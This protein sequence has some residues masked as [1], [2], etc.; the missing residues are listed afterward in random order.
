M[1]VRAN[2]SE[3]TVVPSVGQFRR[4]IQGLRAI[5]VLAVLFHHLEIPYFEGGYVGVDVFFVISGYLITRSIASDLEKG[6]FRFL[7]FY[8][9]RIRRL[10]PAL[11]TT[12]AV[13]LVLGFLLLSPDH[14]KASAEAAIFSIAW[15]S[16][17]LFYWNAGYFDSESLF[18][19]LLHTWSLSV[20]EQ[21]Y[22]VWP[23]LLFGLSLL[24]YRRAIFAG[25]LLLIPLGAIA[26]QMMLVADP[27]AAFFLLP[28]RVFEFAIG[29]ALFKAEKFAVRPSRLHDV[30]L[31]CGLALVGYAILTFSPETPFPGYSALIP[32]VGTALVIFSGSKA[33]MVTG[34]V[35]NP[36]AVW[37]GEISYSL[38]LV[39]WPLV[40]YYRYWVFGDISP[41]EKLLLGI[42][43]ILLGWALFRFIETPLRRPTKTVPNSKFGAGACAA[44]IVL[45]VCATSVIVGEGFRWRLPQDLELRADGTKAL[46]LT[47]SEI[48][49]IDGVSACKMGDKA[50]TAADLV[51]IGD[52]H[53]QAL[54]DAVPA[55]L[56]PKG[57]ALLLHSP[58][59]LPFLHVRTI[60]GSKASDTNFDSTLH[61]V[62]NSDASLV[63]LHARF[64]LHWNTTRP[65][66]E[67]GRPKFV[68][69][70][71]GTAPKD[72]AHSQRNFIKGLTD[73]V[74]L[75]KE[76]GKE[77][78]L[79][80]AVPHLG[81]DL[82]S[83]FSRPSYLL[84]VEQ[85]NDGCGGLTREHAVARAGEVN[86]I[87]KDL[88]EELGYI[89]VDP[90]PIFCPDETAK[91]CR[92]IEGN[93]L[94]YKDDDHVSRYGAEMLLKEAIT[95]ANRLHEEKP[96]LTAF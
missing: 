87:L 9:R 1:N 36:P 56:P 7:D 70:H 95:A 33:R 37:I 62:A 43:S 96:V 20:E 14:F 29:A 60:D 82:P 86:S 72:V 31:L 55:A 92:R 4:D 91:F 75:L 58:G 90:V 79:I 6:T 22:L 38:Y 21:F 49:W 50:R 67:G 3:M 27:S 89:F 44:T 64:A 88:G 12:V 76:S 13:S 54:A 40:V 16:N 80:G 69:D 83:C 11:L 94:L 59:K 17:F 26:S 28:A 77:I 18:K 34:L 68:G 48:Q 74:R 57:S 35:A 84:S 63:M 41:R 39:H 51:L 23:A 93:K 19:P 66:D 30:L 53:A 52:S 47:C 61:R 2:Y 78:V 25:V 8:L 65:S 32:C 85:L 81:V 10:F 45:A 73:T 46:V 15:I 24:S 5:A 42:V 71:Q